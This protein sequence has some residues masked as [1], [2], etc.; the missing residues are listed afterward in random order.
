MKLTSGG[1]DAKRTERTKSSKRRRSARA[2]VETRFPREAWTAARVASMQS[3]AAWTDAIALRFSKALP[4]ME[5]ATVEREVV[6]LLM[7]LLLLLLLL[8]FAALTGL[9]VLLAL[10]AVNV[11]LDALSHLRARGDERERETRRRQEV[12]TEDAPGLASPANPTVARSS[13]IW[14]TSFS[15]LTTRRNMP[16]LD[17][18]SSM[19]SMVDWVNGLETAEVDDVS[20]VC[21]G[22]LKETDPNT[23]P[24]YCD[25][26]YV[27]E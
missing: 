11:V 8:L 7:L 21:S 14:V 12:N 20:T 24:L 2:R 9:T 22:P 3:S 23:P 27:A 16:P 1:A 4:A 19:E 10:Y 5:A 13:R 18:I 25:E 6:L 15:W 26:R 17:T